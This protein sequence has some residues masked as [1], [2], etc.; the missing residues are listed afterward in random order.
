VIVPPRQAERVPSALVERFDAHVSDLYPPDAAARG[1]I[2]VEDRL[3]SGSR[4][5]SCPCRR[6]GVH[7]Q[8]VVRALRRRGGGGNR[9]E[10]RGQAHAGTS[11]AVDRRTS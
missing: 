8:S 7:G 3:G 6:G 1:Y 9:Y 11:F 5:R 4:F 10:G 2:E